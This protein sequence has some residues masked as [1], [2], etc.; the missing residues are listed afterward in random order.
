MEKLAE[1]L[2]Q[3]S[4]GSSLSKLKKKEFPLRII[5][6][7]FPKGRVVFGRT[8]V[9]KLVQNIDIYY[10]S[11]IFGNFPF[12]FFNVNKI[13]FKDIWITIIVY[14][15]RLIKGTASNINEAI[16][17]WGIILIR[18]GKELFDINCK[19]KG[20]KIREIGEGFWNYKGIY[21]AAVSLC[22]SD[23]RDMPTVN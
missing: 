17:D 9:K 8:S 13:V 11:E 14:F 4:F 15:A 23:K 6:H 10:F 7:T 12:F 5:W 21:R 2:H 19:M 20:M 22:F 18:V 1:K 3:R 16:G